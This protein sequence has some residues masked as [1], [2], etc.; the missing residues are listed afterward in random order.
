MKQN[1]S[2]IFNRTKLIN[3]RLFQSK[4]NRSP[5]IF[6]EAAIKYLCDN[7]SICRK[8]FD[9]NVVYFGQDCFYFLENAP[10]SIIISL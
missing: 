4:H 3:N 6:Q 8:T 9:R 2:K 1:I 5:Q 10:F 7:V